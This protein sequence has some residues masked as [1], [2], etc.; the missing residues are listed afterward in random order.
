MN[1]TSRKLRLLLALI[2]A[3]GLC[4]CTTNPYTGQKEFGPWIALKKA[5]NSFGDMLDKANTSP[6]PRKPDWW[7]PDQ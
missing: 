1:L 7:N 4:G 5:D 6:D 2:V 3:G